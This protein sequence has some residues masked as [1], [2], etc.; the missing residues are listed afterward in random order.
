MRIQLRWMQ[1]ATMFIFVISVGWFLALLFLSIAGMDDAQAQVSSRRLVTLLESDGRTATTT[2]ADQ[3]NI[4]E[5]L[6]VNGAYVIL[7]VTGIALTPTITLTIQAK[8]P[9]S[10]EYESILTAASGVTAMGRHTYLVVAGAG[11]A[12]ADVTQVAGFPLPAQWR[13]SVAHANTNTITYSVGA[14]LVP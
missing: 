3:I 10:E 5:N 9:V 11:T 4:G 2:S 7:D 6:N 1:I 14:L 12:S 13:I 8:D